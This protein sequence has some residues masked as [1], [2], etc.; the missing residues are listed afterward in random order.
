M[1]ISFS[2]AIEPHSFV[3]TLVSH[4]S[5]G[6][7]PD[8]FMW[9]LETPVVAESRGAGMTLRAAGIQKV[10]S[11]ADEYMAKSVMMQ[12]Y[13][14]SRPFGVYFGQCTECS[15]KLAAEVILVRALNT[16]SAV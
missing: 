15:V 1:N 6:Q 12:C 7:V 16:E 3:T 11:K 9:T 5:T 14:V 13:A 8:H 10:M 4:T 2:P